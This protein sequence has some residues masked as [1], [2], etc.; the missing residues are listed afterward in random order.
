M[1]REEVLVQR[2][3]ELDVASI[4]PDVRAAMVRAVEEQ[5]AASVAN[6]TP[7]EPTLR[8]FFDAN[9]GRYATE[10]TMTVR[11][12]V[13]TNAAAATRASAAARSDAANAASLLIAAAGRETG[14]VDGAE[15]YFAARLHL[16][17]ILFAAASP[18]PDGAIAVQE[19]AD[20]V[21]ALLMLRNR[22]PS[23][24]P[25]AAVRARVLAD[26]RRD[27]TTRRQAQE[28]AF[29]LKRAHVQIAS[30]LQ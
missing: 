11:D 16:G 3:R 22:P 5:A 25:Y 26:Y 27:A 2:A 24:L 10:G 6:A 13:F 9:Q 4:D 8:A 28:V 7:D 19:A 14:A 29:L 30:D 1:I 23:P 15:F 21:H 18:L 12:F 20:G 17:E